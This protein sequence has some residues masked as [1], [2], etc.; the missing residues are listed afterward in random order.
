LEAEEYHS[1]F[2]YE[3]RHWWYAGLR[4][5]VR[6]SLARFLRLPL[7][8][9]DVGVLDAGCG[10]GMQLKELVQIYGSGAVGIDLS[11][12][13]LALCKERS[14]TAYPI[15]KLINSSV[16][17]LPFKDETFNAVVSLDVLYH[18]G[19]P[20][21][22]AAL[23]E[24]ER[25]LKEDGILILNL[26]AYEFLSGPHDEAVHT[27]ERYTKEKLTG[28]L[29]AAGLRIERITYRNTFLFPIVVIV[30]TLQRLTKSSSDTTTGA[31]DL[32]MPFFLTNAL[33]KTALHMEN[34]CLKAGDL[35]FGSSLFCVARKSAK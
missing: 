29:K 15:E 35:P 1:I 33:L 3:Q 31:S 5:L 8:G 23:K 4:E 20:D 17:E 26:P 19:I 21:D 27:R 34:I 13:S 2:R 24:V 16:S 25:V 28:R 9:N 14:T 10:G 22:V 18:K 32:K 6:S 12:I 11:P 30:R 7:D